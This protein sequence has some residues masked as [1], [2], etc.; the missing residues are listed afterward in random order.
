MADGAPWDAM[1]LQ[2]LQE[3]S[4]SLFNW[5]QLKTDIEVGQKRTRQGETAQ[6]W[7]LSAHLGDLAPSP[8]FSHG[9]RYSFSFLKALQGYMAE[10]DVGWKAM[11]LP[12]HS[13]MS[14]VQRSPLSSL[15]WE[16][17]LPLTLPAFVFCLHVANGPLSYSSP[18][19]G[20]PHGR[21]PQNQNSISILRS[22]LLP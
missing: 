13:P 10:W 11:F 22:P 19:C 21:G 1:L 3:P 20:W 2:S 7:A 5:E 4:K 6:H 18:G 9:G 8:P 14:S 16:R 15:E 12:S 17:R